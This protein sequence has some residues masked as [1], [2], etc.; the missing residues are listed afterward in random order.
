MPSYVLPQVLVFQEF[1]TIPT[2]LA[3][4][5]RACIIGPQYDLHRY[6]AADEKSGIYVG[7]YDP[8]SD[9]CYLWPGRLPGGVVDMD[10]TKV[11]I[12]NALLQYFNDPAGDPSVITWV[13]P[14]K[15]R[16]RA[17]SVIWQTAN[18]YARSASLLRDVKI[19]DA[20]KLL[21][22]SCGSPITL[23]SYVSGLIA[24]VIASIIDAAAADIS[25]QADIGSTT[26]TA[27]QTAGSHN[28][29]SADSV[30]ASAYDGLPDGKVTETYTVV[31]IAGSTGGDATSALLRVTSAS[32]LDDVA[33][34]TPS[35][36]GAPTPIGAR[37]LT[38]TWGNS[39]ESSESSASGIDPNDFL[40]GQTWVI[41]VQQQYSKP[42]PASGGNYV[43]GQ[44]TTYVVEVT[45]GGS[46]ASPVK[47]QV[48][49]TTTTGID[50]SGP[51]TV[52]AS[53]TAVVVGTQGVT[54]SF[55]GTALCK[56][57]RFLIPVT[58]AANGPVRT[59]VLANNLPDA[60]RGD[61]SSGSSS[62]SGAPPDL[63]VT[64]YIK[65]NIEVPENRTGYAPLVNWE[66]TETEICLKLGIISYDED[67]QTG[68]ILQPLPVMGGSVYAQHRDLVASAC[69]TVGT[70]ADVSEVPT[71]LGTV[72]PDNPLAFGVYKALENSNGEEVKYIGVCAHSPIELDDWLAALEILVGRDDV[73]SLVPLTQDKDILDAVLAHCEAESSPE[74]G[75][76]R[77]CW[78]NM[79]AEEVIGI[80]TTSTKSGG[81]PVLATITDD[82]DTSGTQYTLVEA[83][84]ETFITK[85]VRSGDT[86][87][88]LYTSDGFG[89][90]TY[91]EFIV[92]VVLNEESIRLV[93]GPSAPV[94]VPS[95][96]EIWRTLTKTE[97]AA[98]LAQKPG[99]F[100]SRR[101]SLV[102]PD[103]VGNAGVTFPGYFLCAGLA[104]LRSG[105]LPHQGLT[106]VEIQ[107]FDDLSRTTEFF[108][109]NQLN[110]MAASGYWIVTQDP[111]DGTVF[112]RHQ[113]TTGD[114][115]NV[116]IKEQ[117]VTTNLD[118]IS[119]QF[120]SMLKV[121]IGR[122]NVTET[123]INI[124]RGDVIALC[125]QLKNTITVD[126]LGPQMLDA[127]ILEL[128]QHPTLLD[129]IVCRIDVTLPV[130]FNNMELHLIV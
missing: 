111:N 27:V 98:E 39:S 51:T 99:L 29:V 2:P 56:G 4:P 37:G 101:A 129:R 10:Y 97:L 6:S 11:F 58:A 119:Y 71:L 42:V 127:V 1:E 72:D 66:Q 115:T 81:G 45:R 34:V 60:L 93:S 105:V 89:N 59:L 104:G 92:D 17:D 84:G 77:I 125:Q 35:A 14:G 8:L 12:D 69:A 128:A 52:P 26:G 102:W 83:T 109:A 9:Q 53:G 46:F 103:E 80:Y 85:G 67:W 47:P 30:D 113:L 130:P 65:K 122:G 43:G 28:Y 63:D 94:N 74:N 50:L 107:G 23:W 41:D 55:T 13:A 25:N 123:M 40:I 54:I 24:D 33:E 22:S 61:C 117:S 87:R 36:F 5:Q 79:A 106:N 90:L 68:G 110:T 118:N 70:A 49:V 82:P 3:Q 91:T 88:A 112:T 20:I 124:I 108:S 19:G 38:V 120:L 16:I 57:D 96:I 95:K 78:L 75:R 62:S 32:G 76:W 15:N 116:N 126:R 114:Q 21:A 86:V 64:L 73:Y 48:T 121:Y 44:D 100:K 18:G 7:Q 31:V